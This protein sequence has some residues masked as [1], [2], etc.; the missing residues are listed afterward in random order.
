MSGDAKFTRVKCCD[1]HG[2][3]PCLAPKPLSHP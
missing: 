1:G 3:R 2:L